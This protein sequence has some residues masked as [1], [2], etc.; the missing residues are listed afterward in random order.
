MN[1]AAE[2][3]KAEGAI[4]AYIDELEAGKASAQTTI[5]GLMQAAQKDG[6]TLA[7][8]QETIN[9]QATKITGYQQMIAYLKQQLAAYNQVKP[10]IPFGVN[11]HP[12]TNA[13]YADIPQMIKD[14]QT[15]G[16]NAVRIDFHTDKTGL[17]TNMPLYTKL[18]AALSDAKLYVQPMFSINPVLGSTAAIQEAAGFYIGT[19]YVFDSCEIGNEVDNATILNATVNGTKAA[20][21]DPAKLTKAGNCIKNLVAGIKRAQA[22]AKIIVDVAWIHHGFLDEIINTFKVPVDVPAQHWYTNQELSYAGTPI[23]QLI[24]TKYP[25]TPAIFNEVGLRPQADG[26][27]RTSDFP[28]LQNI[29]IRF[30]RFGQYFNELYNEPDRGLI[31]GNFGVFSKPGVPVLPILTVLKAVQA[32]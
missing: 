4:Q 30:K 11:I 21:F 32:S 6:L 19:N 24:A 27:L 7:S 17:I 13:A 16:F 2:Y 8:Q 25:N 12:F 28:V 10:F 18:M 23:E 26:T 22:N 3:S 9:D 15:V 20:D 5:D 31:E 29:M 1:V 14:I